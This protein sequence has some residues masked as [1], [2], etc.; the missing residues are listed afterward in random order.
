MQ[1]AKTLITYGANPN[2][3]DF[4]MRT[5]LQLAVR[6]GDADMVEL[7]LCEGMRIELGYWWEQ[8]LVDAV[9]EVRAVGS[10][11]MPL[12]ACGESSYHPVHDSL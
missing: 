2:A 6:H 10:V 4:R 1:A 8:P 7:L 3:S 5:P 12:Q 11:P 9:K